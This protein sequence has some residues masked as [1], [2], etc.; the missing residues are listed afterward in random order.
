[1]TRRLRH[2]ESSARPARPFLNSLANLALGDGAWI[3]VSDPNGAVWQ[4]PVVD[5]ARE[6]SLVPQ[7]NLV[8]WTGADGTPVGEAVAGILDALDALFIWDPRADEFLSY[9]PG[10]PAF[11]NTADVLNYGDGI[12]LKM[13]APAV[14]EQSAS[15]LS[16]AS[17]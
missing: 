3:N 2:S 1:M 12:W 11:L 7:F 4:V 8:V 17:R 10:A 14:W 5:A 15:G 9:R 13:S 6:V 16:V